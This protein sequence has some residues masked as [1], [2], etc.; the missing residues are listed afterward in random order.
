MLRYIRIY[1]ERCQALLQR[2]VLP[3]RRLAELSGSPQSF[4]RATIIDEAVNSPVI[5]SLDRCLW[6]YVDGEPKTS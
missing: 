2:M 5:R 6:I 3:V 1:H 4:V